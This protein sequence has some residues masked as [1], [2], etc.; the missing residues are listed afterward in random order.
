MQPER[1]RMGGSPVRLAYSSLV[2]TMAACGGNVALDPAGAGGQNNT[3]MGGAA[4]GGST[5]SGTDVSVD[6]SLTG[7]ISILT[8]DMWAQIN[9]EA[10]AGL[11]FDWPISPDDASASASVLS[12]IY[13]P[14]QLASGQIL[15][16][17]KLNIVFSQSS[18]P[19]VRY[20]IGLTEPNC[21]QG[22]GWYLN[23]DDQ[24]VLCAK[25]CDMVMQDPSGT[26]DFRMGCGGPAILN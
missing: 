12:C 4:S 5:A 1:N 3:T 17:N 6:D 19:I 14:P 18:Q 15:D 24:I 16:P 26:I 13:P 23:S 8:P 10:C 22:D 7:G 9:D 25:T 20:L 11:Y 2:L 21:P